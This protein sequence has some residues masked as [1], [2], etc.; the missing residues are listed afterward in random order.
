LDRTGF[1][2]S[3][4]QYLEQLRILRIDGVTV[5]RIDSAKVVFPNKLSVLEFEFRKEGWTSGLK[6]IGTLVSLRR[7]QLSGFMSLISLADT[8]GLMRTLETCEI[9]NCNK[10][11]DLPDSIGHLQ[12][13]SKLTL[14][15]CE[16]LRALPE[17]FGQLRAEH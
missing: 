15:G 13:L 7:F 3:V 11:I 6:A 17:A 12:R 5:R 16:S 2:V 14:L 8:L 9:H 1:N 10:L 4:F